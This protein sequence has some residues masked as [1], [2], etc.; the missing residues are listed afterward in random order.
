MAPDRGVPDGGGGEQ[1]DAQRETDGVDVNITS[2]PA[3]Q[4]GRPG[5]GGVGA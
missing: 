5:P 4:Q 2:K 3:R 1:G